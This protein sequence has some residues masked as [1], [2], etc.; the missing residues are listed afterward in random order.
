MA[1]V[2]QQYESDTIKAKKA[3]KQK[4]QSLSA[5][6]LKDIVIE[7]G[8]FLQDHEKRLRKIEEKLG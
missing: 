5:G 7:I 2:R 4:V 1:D 6:D 3:L 8:K